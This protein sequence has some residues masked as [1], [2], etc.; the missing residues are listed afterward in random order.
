MLK[1]KINQARGHP[2][3]RGAILLSQRTS[4]WYGADWNEVLKQAGW[5]SGGRAAQ[6]RAET[7][8]C[9]EGL[10][11]SERASVAGKEGAMGGEGKR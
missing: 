4:T 2:E 8:R 9:L 7:R 3:K 1:R 11:R 10:R 6:A 5:I